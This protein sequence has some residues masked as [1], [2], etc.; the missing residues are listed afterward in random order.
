MEI[1]LVLFQDMDGNRALAIVAHLLAIHLP[2]AISI[3][4][5]VANENISIQAVRRSVQQKGTKPKENASP[6]GGEN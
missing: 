6:N 2:Y 5:D 3:K 4:S 1:S